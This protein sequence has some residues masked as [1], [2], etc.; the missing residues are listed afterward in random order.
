MRP[1]TARR[2]KPPAQVEGDLDAIVANMPDTFIDCRTIGHSWRKST[3]DYRADERVWVQ[4]LKC[5]RCKS[6]CERHADDHGYPLGNR[7]VYVEGY[8]IEGL[9]AF[10]QNKRAAVRLASLLSTI[11]PRGTA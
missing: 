2:R 11:T 9:G 10:D 6:V 4:A 1:N 7:Y 3:A 8:R 5:T